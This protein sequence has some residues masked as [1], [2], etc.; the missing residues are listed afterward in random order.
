[1]KKT[2][3]SRKTTIVLNRVGGLRAR[4]NG[5]RH[6]LLSLGTQGVTKLKE[7]PVGAVVGA[8]ATGV[9]VAKLVGRG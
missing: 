9:A 8:F 3:R 6:A 7:H 2:T 5:A 1:M 4:M